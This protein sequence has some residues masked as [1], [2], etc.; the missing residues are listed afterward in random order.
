M[1]AVGDGGG[2]PAAG[3]SGLGGALSNAVWNRLTSLG[4]R[5]TFKTG[6]LLMDQTWIGRHVFVLLTGRVKVS[7]YDEDH[8]E[9]VLAVR[10]RGE[11][12]GELSLFGLHSR[13][14]EVK[15]ATACEVREI[16]GD[17]F[18]RFVDAEKLTLQINNHLTRR[19]VEEMRLREITRQR[20]VDL[21]L[22]RGL[23]H[24]AKSAL[25][26]E[27]EANI[28]D[29]DRPVDIWL[30]H[31]D[32]GKALDIRRPTVTTKLTELRKAEVVDT[33]WG[34]VTVLDMAALVTRC[35]SHPE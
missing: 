28:A 32:L 34:H 24:F 15:A 30:S 22:A 20:P 6:T 4:V 27:P 33:G 17:D 3:R 35:Q 1:P 12:L 16:Q 2:T 21:R 23:L 8:H 19:W 14:A 29:H 10:G 18:L 11:I 26:V 9:L 25:G 13:S 5:R 7:R 31:E